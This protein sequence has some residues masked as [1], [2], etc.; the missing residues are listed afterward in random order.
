ME[1]LPGVGETTTYGEESRLPPCSALANTSVE[2]E[3][4]NYTNSYSSMAQKSNIS[5]TQDLSGVM[6]DLEF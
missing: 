5:V 1:E 4:M 3:G 6:L 2:L